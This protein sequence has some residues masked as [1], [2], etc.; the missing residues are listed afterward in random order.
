[1]PDLPSSA[2]AGAVDQSASRAPA[3]WPCAAGQVGVS[4]QLRS[5]HGQLSL[6][7]QCLDEQDRAVLAFARAHHWHGRI[8]DALTWR[9]LGVHAT[10]YFQL[11]SRVAGAARGVRARAGARAA[12]TCAARAPPPATTPGGR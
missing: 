12:A 8:D 10:R 2:P 7:E 5:V 9:E 3:R 11:R 4:R 6:L 1:M